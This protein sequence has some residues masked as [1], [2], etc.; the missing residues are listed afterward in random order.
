MDLPP[1]ILP[2]PFSSMFRPTITLTRNQ[3]IVSASSSAAERAAALSAKSPDELWKPDDAYAMVAGRLPAGIFFLNVDDS[4]VTIPAMVQALPILV[5]QLNLMVPAVETARTAATNAQSVNQLKQIGLAFHNFHDIN[6]AFPR[7]AIVDKKGKPLLS[8]RVAILPLLEQEGLYRKFKLDEPWDSPHNKALLDE[9][10]EVFRSP[11]R[12]DVAATST[13]YRGL[14]GKGALFDPRG[15]PAN[16]PKPAAGVGD[17]G[18]KPAD[19]ANPGAGGIGLADITDGTSNTIMVVEAEKGV[20]WTKPDE[21][22]F[23]PDAKPSLYGAGSPGSDVFLVLM[24]D[25][26]VRNLRKLVDKKA[27]RALVTRDGGEVIDANVF[28]TP[29]A[30]RVRPRPGT[31]TPAFRFDASK[32]PRTDELAKRL[33]PAT[34]SISVDDTGLSFIGREAFPS[35]SSP[36]T[37]AVLIALL[38]PAVQS[39]REAA[40]RAQCVNNEKQIGLAMH[41][42]HSSN[43]VFPKPAITDKDGK[44]LLSWR[45]AI[46]PYIEHK[47]LYDRFK[48]DEPWDSPHNKALLKEMP[49]TYLCP[50]RSYKGDYTT[51][52][53]LMVGPG[54]MFEKDGETGIQH[55]TDGTSNTIMVLEAETPVPWSKPDDLVFDPNAKPSFYG[56]GSNHPGGFNAVFGDGSVRFLKK[57]ISL[58]VFKALL[59]R[60]GGEVLRSDSF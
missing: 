38:L 46:L 15:K 40:R 47:D 33:F 21:L 4:R 56:A 22:E 16:G 1:G 24:G 30:P 48:L 37:S 51:T 18:D 14:S 27:F 11:S 58:Q 41:N 34:S 25:G 20:P 53:Q 43:N 28:A 12:R 35:I 36:S 57:S 6:G 10:P 19:G 59:T 26:S 2:P 3:L 45:V 31:V 60:A 49:T 5:S 55:I 13:V 7:P 39:A 42:F 50:S 9:M 32:L 44:P 54:A 23:D 29:A 8:W 17:V 52:Y